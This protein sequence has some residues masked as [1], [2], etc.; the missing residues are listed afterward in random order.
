LAER[1]GPASGD[2]FRGSAALSA[3]LLTRAALRGRHYRR[4][5]PDMY[6]PAELPP[7][8]ALRSRAAFLWGRG[9]GV[10][11][12]YSAAELL[13]SECAPADAPAEL[14]LPAAHQRSPKGLIVRQVRLADDEYL[15]RGGIVLTTPLRT[16]YDLARQCP[17]VEA[18]VAV[19]ALAGRYGFTGAD[20]T[21]F[22]ER[23]VGA[24]GTL[25]LADMVGLV[26]PAAE[27]AM[28]TRL[29]L[30]IVHG[31]LPRPVAQHLVADERGQIVA[32]VD[33]AYPEAL[34]A[35]EYE[36]AEHFTDR[37]VVR[38]GRRYTQL[39]DLGWR[40]FRYFAHDVYRRPDRI[41]T[42][43]RRALT[44][45][46]IPRPRQP[47]DRLRLSAAEQLWLP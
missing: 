16:A 31:G 9:R 14:A 4:L 43:L 5:L 22:A 38:D 13:G 20:L 26:E 24:R 6:A 12:G 33:L 46:A 25:R 45:P 28:E 17:L 15:A 21:A 18:V 27:S 30:V 41:T 10:L 32:R 8:L 23:Y 42:E 2:V 39:A 35:I 37:Q 11:A 29:R 1:A 47:V 7:D 19:D 36:G 44:S 34:V 3:G 40:V